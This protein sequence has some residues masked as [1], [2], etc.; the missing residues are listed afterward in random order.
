MAVTEG[1][2]KMHPLSWRQKCQFFQVDKVC[3]TLYACY[4]FDGCSKIYFHEW[5]WGGH[6]NV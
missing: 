3:P 4:D 2:K 1:G 5:G 6:Y